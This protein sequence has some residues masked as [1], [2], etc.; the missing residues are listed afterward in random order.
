MLGS[1]EKTDSIRTECRD[2]RCD[3]LIL[4]RNVAD[5]RIPSACE[6]PYSCV[7]LFGAQAERLV[8]LDHESSHYVGVV[9]L[10]DMCQ[11]RTK[12]PQGFGDVHV[13]VCSRI[14]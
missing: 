11:N 4:P 9:G 8:I 14:T 12:P 13:T 6:Y 10:L 3:N 2:K 1:T 7:H 5:L